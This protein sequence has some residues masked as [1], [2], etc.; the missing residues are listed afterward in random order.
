VYS[1]DGGQSQEG[2]M[3]ASGY[4]AVQ[5]YALYLKEPLPG[6]RM[7]QA[8]GCGVPTAQAK[9]FL[10]WCRVWRLVEAL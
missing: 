8:L 5:P 6:V 2:T 4:T 9:F 10:D 3:A 1:T 7:H